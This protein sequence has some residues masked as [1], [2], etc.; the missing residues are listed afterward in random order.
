MVCCDRGLEALGII[1]YHDNVV[2]LFSLGERVVTLVMARA[3]HD[4]RRD[5]RSVSAAANGV[6]LAT[7]PHVDMMNYAQQLP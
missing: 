5:R 1:S 2:V 7:E 3:L 4:R 6:V